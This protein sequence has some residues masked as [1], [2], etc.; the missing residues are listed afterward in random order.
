M[1]YLIPLLTGSNFEYHIFMDKR[2]VYCKSKHYVGLNLRRG[3]L[4][5]E[6]R[7]FLAKKM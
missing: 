5:E 6:I 1:D 2:G 4:L 3:H 7:Y